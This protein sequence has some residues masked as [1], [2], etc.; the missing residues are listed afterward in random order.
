MNSTEIYR[1][2]SSQE[3]EIKELEEMQ[4]AVMNILEDSDSEKSG[5]EDF[6]RATLNI[7]EDLNEERGRFEE[8][9]SA[10]LNILDDASNEK[11]RLEETQRASLNILEDFDEEKNHLVEVQKATLNILEDFN[12]EKDRLEETQKA[13]LNILEDFNTEKEKVTQAYEALQREVEARKEAEKY[14]H[15]LAAL[16]DSADDAIFSKTTEGIITSWNKGAEKLYG[17]TSKEAVGSHIS[18]LVPKGHRDEV[19]DFL[20]KIKHNERVEHY[21]TKRYRKDGEMVD[22]SLTL[23]PIRD[24]EGTIVGVSAVARDITQR[25][26]AEEKLR[27]AHNELE[28]R[29]QERTSQLSKVNVALQEQIGEREKAEERFRMVVES[30]PN[31]MVMIDE[32]GTIVLI[33]KMTESLFGYH[34][35]ELLEQSIDKLLPDSQLIQ[36]GIR[37]NFTAL[38]AG[39]QMRIEQDVFGCTRVGDQVPVEIG[40]NPVATNEG[41]YILATIVD[42]TERRKAEALIKSKN[43]E[44]ET[45]LY[46]VSHD[47]KEPLRGIEYFSTAV[48]ERYGG[49]LDP[50]GKDYLFRVVKA[51][52]RMRILLNEILMISRARRFNVS[53]QFISGKVI[54]NEAL[55]RLQTKID[56]TDARIQISSEF[57]KYKVEKTWAVQAVFNL[58]NN[59]LKYSSKGKKPDITITPFS[60]GTS[61]KSGQTGIIVSDRGPGVEEEYRIKIFELFQRAVNREVEGTGAGLAIVREVALRHGGEAWVEARKGGGS[62]FIITFGNQ[63]QEKHARVESFSH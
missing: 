50:K 25:K 24:D 40:L 2:I 58:I 23:S 13:T 59:A 41:N 39:Q 48:K 5:V 16:V 61:L 47:L 38:N 55:S 35:H 1:Q 19:A 31:A 11:A 8:T 20:T 18:F 27:Q 12:T 14:R 7:L 29:V 56:E 42:V 54:I 62:R 57:P 60:E 22:V 32:K 53:S 37:A 26:E 63:Y 51:A 15:Y 45:L 44:L 28:S 21:E 10:V 9:Q 30:A 3:D 6:Q 34:R 43:Q 33:N 17:Y 52:S 46:I 49:E 4:R 36:E